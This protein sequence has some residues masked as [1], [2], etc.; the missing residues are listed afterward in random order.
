MQVT[1]PYGGQILFAGATASI[2]WATNAPSLA[3]KLVLCHTGAN[4]TCA[5][6]ATIVPRFD[7]TAYDDDTP[8]GGSYAWP[9]PYAQQ[10]ASD[11]RVL[12]Q[13]VDV[14][15]VSSLG[16]E[17]IISTCAALS[18]CSGSSAPHLTH[19]TTVVQNQLRMTTLPMAPTLALA[20]LVSSVSAL[21]CYCCGNA[22]CDR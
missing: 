7:S 5:H 11:Y 18:R 1:T 2:T 13:A 15:S 9:V 20:L 16:D 4:G 12:V 10:A 14:P 21:W 6:P 19:V 8:D 22:A 17:F 3:V